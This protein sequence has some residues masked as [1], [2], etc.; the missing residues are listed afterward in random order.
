LPDAD[1]AVTTGSPLLP[2]R[3]SASLAWLGAAGVAV[4]QD[5][6]VC[7]GLVAAV[8]AAE[9]WMRARGELGERFGG[10]RMGAGVVGGLSTSMRWCL[11][12]VRWEAAAIGRGWLAADL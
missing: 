3:Q 7:Q 2:P 6:K 10:V 12:C 1:A 11:G 8:G 5:S 4:S 9:D